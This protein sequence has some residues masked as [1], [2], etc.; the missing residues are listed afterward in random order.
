M[1]SRAAEHLALSREQGLVVGQAHQCCSRVTAVHSGALHTT[2]WFLLPLH[3]LSV[4]CQSWKL[5]LQTELQLLQHSVAFVMSNSGCLAGSHKRGLAPLTHE[6][7]SSQ[8]TVSRDAPIT[9]STDSFL[10]GKLIWQQEQNATGGHFWRNSSVV[11][12]H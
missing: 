12:F 7:A 5:L 2:G 11:H 6:L 9:A 4:I 3:K 10:T 1:K 8:S